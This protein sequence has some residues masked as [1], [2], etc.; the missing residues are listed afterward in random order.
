MKTRVLV[1][2]LAVGAALVGAAAYAA[3]RTGEEDELIT[4]DELRALTPRLTEEQRR[5][6]LPHLVR[7]LAKWEITTLPRLAAALGQWLH[8]SWQ[9]SALQEIA[10]DVARYAANAGL[11]NSSAHAAKKFIGRGATMLTGEANY[12]RA[13]AALG[14]DLVGKPELAADPRYT[15]DVAGW[16]WRKGTSADLNALAD[17][18]EFEAITRRIN[19]GT[20]GAEDRRRYHAQAMAVL[21]SR[22]AKQSEEGERS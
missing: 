10:P 2:A 16:F 9:F 1:G 8:E 17:A 5:T 4:L 13:A 19:G 11:G 12:K 20:N 21:R 22:L 3:R 15:F 18:G 14:V 6:Y 7:A